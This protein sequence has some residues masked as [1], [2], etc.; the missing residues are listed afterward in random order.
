M[1]LKTID[2][3]DLNLI[4]EARRAAATTYTQ[5]DLL[6]TEYDS[7]IGDIPEGKSVGDVKEAS[8]TRYQVSFDEEE[9][10]AAKNAELEARIAALEG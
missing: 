2:A 9:E 10:N 5:P 6:Y 8:H 3:K 4:P 1:G 7:E